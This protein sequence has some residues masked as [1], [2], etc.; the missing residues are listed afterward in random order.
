MSGGFNDYATTGLSA[1]QTAIKKLNADIIG[2]VDTY[3][4]DTLYTQAQ[5]AKLFDYKFAYCI[6][7]NDKRLQQLG[8]DNGITLLSNIPV[9]PR[10]VRL[11]TR[12]AII[13]QVQHGT[14]PPFNMAVVYLDDLSE[15]TRLQQLQALRALID[16]DQPLMI[17]G[18]LNTI[19]RRDINHSNIL[20]GTFYRRNPSLHKKLKPILNDMQKGE[21]VAHL[22]SWGLLDAGRKKY[23]PTFPTPLFPADT[24]QPFLRLDY[25]FYSPSFTLSRYNVLYDEAFKAASD[26]FPILLTIKA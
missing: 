24:Q 15:A 12:N 7:L 3:R 5:L 25:C 1:L 26:H 4:W 8:H 19:A 22:E 20:I 23:L 10:T 9:Q 18:D 13:A 14:T 2:L 11:A 6:A 16:L 17:M 21:V